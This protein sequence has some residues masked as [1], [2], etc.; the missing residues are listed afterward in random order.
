M[1]TNYLRTA[2]RM[3]IK[4]KGFSAVNIGGLAIGLTACIVILQYVSFESSFDRFHSKA[5]RIYRVTK[6]NFA[7]GTMNDH[8][9][10]TFTAT[11]PELK[12]AFP[13]IASATTASEIY[14][15]GVVSFGDVK[16]NEE[17][18]LYADSAFLTIFDFP[19]VRGNIERD[20]NQPNAVLISE[21]ASRKYF[22]NAD[23]I[24]KTL[25]LNDDNLLSV[26]GVIK[27]VPANSHIHFD[28]LIYAGYNRNNNNYDYYT[29]LQLKPGANV[30]ELQAKLPAYIQRAGLDSVSTAFELQPLTSIHLYSNIRNE[31]EVNG[32]SRSVYFL[33]VIAGFIL[34][35]A[36]VN[37][38]NLSTARSVRRAKEVG[39]RKVVGASRAQLIRQF[40]FESLVINFF[41]AAVASILLRF[42][43]PYFADLT[44][45]PLA[46]R[47]WNYGG[48]WMIFIGVFAAGT[49]LSA[50]YPAFVMSAFKPLKVIKGFSKTSGGRTLRKAL[51]TVQFAATVFLLIGTFTVFR[52][53]KFMRS[54]NLGINIEQTLVINGPKM[55]GAND[56]YQAFKNKLLRFPQVH[57]MTRSSNVPGKE[58]WSA[59][60][61]FRL[62][63]NPE[64]GVAMNEVD[65]DEDFLETFQIQLLSGR[66]LSEKNMADVDNGILLNQTASATLGFAKPGDA[67]EQHV[68]FRGDTFLVKGVL[69]NYHQE[70][71]KND[72]NPIIFRLG[73]AYNSFFSLKL[74]V[75]DV[76]RTIAAIGKEY[77]NF[78]PDDP[79]EYFFLDDLFDR[80]YRADQQLGLIFLWFACLAIFVACL[81]L[82]G[83]ASFTIAQRTKEVGIRKVLG[84]S[85]TG[86]VM[87]LSKEFMMLVV[88]AFLIAMPLAWYSM[89]LWLEDF[90]YRVPLGW[91]V[92]AIA[93]AIA[94]IIA[95]ITVSYQAFHAAFSNPVKTLR[96]E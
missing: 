56:S 61:A 6:K 78:F 12:S 40:L 81:G 69:K 77:R 80:Q 30:N 41:A 44:G 50:I 49:L 45:K 88:V 73:T 28:F 5:E 15:S 65:V 76:N 31:A 8:S 58:I 75:A 68:V 13:E 64:T 11:A 79:F 22:N 82:F 93:G 84:A 25:K 21:S 38:I 57:R 37:Y 18:I 70:S 23:P 9:A 91:T 17:K 16:F 71:L 42:T 85:V 43:L 27:D 54:Q 92:F 14:G 33:I 39:I 47:I 55:T 26:V 59:N 2:W 86:I 66:K 67:L 4:N 32:N 24:G 96:T 7:E 74:N 51:V 10:M 83:L 36:W 63:A 46:D 20:F 60:P 72:I 87:L 52:Q 48:Y 62:A 29:Y 94:L 19:V 53:L 3:L 34:A 35:I 89:N 90:A 1:V 95:G